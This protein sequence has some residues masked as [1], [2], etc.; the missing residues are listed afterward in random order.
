LKD[1]NG[2]EIYEGDV[3]G[4]LKLEVSLTPFSGV[5]VARGP[6]YADPD[7]LIEMEVTGNIHDK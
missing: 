6:M 5:L 7:D 4:E 3:I 2:R 1:K